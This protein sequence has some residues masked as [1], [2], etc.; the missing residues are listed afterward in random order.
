MSTNVFNILNRVFGV[1][2]LPFPGKP[3][4]EDNKLIADDFVFE[5]KE[6]NHRSKK[7][8]PLYAQNA[9]GRWMFLPAKLD[10]VLL[11]NAIVS[12]NGE[13]EVVET[14]LIDAGTVFE[15]VFTRPYDITIIC[16]LIQEND[17]WPEEQLIEMYN[18]WK[19]DDVLTLECPLTDIFLQPR[20]NFILK[21][22]NLL[23]MYGVE[24]A[25]VI[26]LTGRSN[27]DFELEIK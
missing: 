5:V 27:V 6:E 4:E 23:D 13:K 19:K 12:F 16:T 10:G 22:F 3:N 7:G 20:N 25:Q 9:L 17:E 18:V 2:G 21:S 26:Q 14:N 24:N 11:Q 15:K 1:R 8:T